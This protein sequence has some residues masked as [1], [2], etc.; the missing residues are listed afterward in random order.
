MNSQKPEDREE[1]LV[2][3]GSERRSFFV[4]L[5]AQSAG[6][7][8]NDLLFDMVPLDPAYRAG[9]AGHA[10]VKIPVSRGHFLLCFFFSSRRAGMRLPGS[11]P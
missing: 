6:L 5:P 3:Q 7:P 4:K 11:H 1:G 8:G 10:P 9:L 2:T